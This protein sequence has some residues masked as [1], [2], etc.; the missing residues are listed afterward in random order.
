MVLQFVIRELENNGTLV[1]DRRFYCLEGRNVLCIYIS[2]A[3]IDCITNYTHYHGAV[4]PLRLFQKMR[5]INRVTHI[6]ATMCFIC[7]CIKP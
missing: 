3:A 7:L 4:N 6:D 1:E 2:Y 5:D